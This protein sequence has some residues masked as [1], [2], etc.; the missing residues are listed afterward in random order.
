MPHRLGALALVAE[1]DSLVRMEAADMLGDA[2]FDVLEASTGPAALAHLDRHSG[3]ALLFTDVLMPGRF[4]GLALAHEARRRWSQ[5]PIVIV[6]GRVNPSAAHLPERARFLSKPYDS[7]T[8]VRVIR[9]MGVCTSTGG[10]S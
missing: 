2:G 3:V 7:H 9:E 8:L 4:D 1:D 5:M 6:S 10:V